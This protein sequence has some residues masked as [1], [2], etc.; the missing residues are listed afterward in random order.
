MQI[1]ISIYLNIF[2]LHI[3]YRNIDKHYNLFLNEK[4][5]IEL[6]QRRYNEINHMYSFFDI[7]IK[8]ML[9]SL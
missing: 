6:L 9:K 3:Y 4:C 2:I 7:M 5:V 1:F 8:K